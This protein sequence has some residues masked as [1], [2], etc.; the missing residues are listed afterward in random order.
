MPVARDRSR[1]P[2]AP[3]LDLD[4]IAVCAVARQLHDDQVVAFG[5]HAEA[6]LAAALVAQRLHAPDLRIRHGLRTERGM[7]HGAAAWTD[8]RDDDSWRRIEYLESHDA[9][10]RVANPRSP[11]RFCDVFFVGG[12]QIDRE[13][14]TN[15]IGLK[16][17][18][19]R[20]AVRGP[21]SIGTTSI[22]TLAR[23][24]ILF[25]P[26]HTPRRFVEQVD[27]VSVP[28]WKRRAAARLQGGPRL[29]I[30]SK[31]VMDFEDGEMRLQSVHPGV[32]VE[33]VEAATGFELR[34]PATVPTTAPPT[35]AERT[36]LRHLGITDTD[37]E[38]GA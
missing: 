6:M 1:T 15:L 19:H 22:A 31:A 7:V 9:I 4:A 24:I 2:N 30:T 8:R 28:G 17:P 18:D 29:V 25:S 36:A 16:G 21:G 20:L 26:E 32:T 14:S 23:E 13:G 35:D 38:T 12:I 34:I 27:Y 10:L 5:L 37:I 11:M 33:E 3:K